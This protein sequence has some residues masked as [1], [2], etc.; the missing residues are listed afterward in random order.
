MKSFDRLQA[1]TWRI[2]RQLTR[3]HRSIALIFIA[4]LIVM[5]LIG[6]SFQ[7]QP[8]VLNRTAP[9]I[10]ATMSLVFI[11]GNILRIIIGFIH[12]FL[13][14]LLHHFLLYMEHCL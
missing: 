13:Y 2:I 6:F 9:A 7:N 12:L 5:S 10:I 14:L 11:L 8:I 1:I 4:P 3:D